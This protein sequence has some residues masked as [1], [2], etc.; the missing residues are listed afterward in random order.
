VGRSDE[1]RNTE[2]TMKTVDTH[3]KG[4]LIERQ[5]SNEQNTM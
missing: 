3:A 4:V 2:E 1:I 5:R